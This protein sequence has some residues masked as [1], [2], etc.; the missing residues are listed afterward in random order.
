MGFH[1]CI[2]LVLACL[3]AISLAY[4][5]SGNKILDPNGKPIL[6][7]GVARPSLEWSATGEHL[8]LSDYQLI[9]GWGANVVRLGLSQCYWL[10][11]SSLYNANYKSTI[12]QQ[13]TWIKGL[14]L[15]VIIDL[16]WSNQGVNSNSCGQ[17]TM[18]DSNSLTFWK[19]VATKYLNDPLVI[20]ELYNEPHDVSWSV[21]KNG[22]DAGGYNT[23]GM[24]AA[25]NAVRATGANNVV[26][27]NGLNYAFDLTGIPA[28]AISGSNIVYGTHPY[29]YSGKQ[30]SDYDSAFG[31]LASTYPLIATEFGEYNCNPTYISN[32]ID[33]AN[34]KSMSWTAWAWY[35]NGCGFPSLIADWSGTPTADG[36]KVKSS[37]TSDSKVPAGSSSS[38]STTSTPTSAP[39]SAP[40]TTTGSSTASGTDVYIDSVVNFA[41][42]SWATDKNAAE[43][44]VVMGTKSYRFA[45]ANYG[46]VYF[47]KAGFINPS[48]HKSI[49]FY[50]NIGSNSPSGIRLNFNMIQ[51]T[52]SSS[53]KVGPDLSVSS[54][55]TLQSNTWVKGTV[56]LANFPSQAY[57]GFWFI[58]QNGGAQS[59]VY[60]DN[61]RVLNK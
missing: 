17:Q 52:G 50:I 35:V 20:F 30:V 34:R 49:E 14:G 48:A 1:G 5:T 60:I 47:Y 44:T 61:I 8:S 32:F 16:H 26:I 39:T 12:D 43:S 22:G 21:W 40:S 57:D 10:S 41:D 36:Q 6:L 28:N 56:N 15:G 53:N 55:A 11:T 4:S 29:D 9:K 54:Y 19:E 45:P 38:S 37:L 27:I 7:R 51:Y 31:N 2:L 18:L 23:P 46:A 24:L 33:Y 59:S 3:I 42:W 25:Y 58:D 13:V